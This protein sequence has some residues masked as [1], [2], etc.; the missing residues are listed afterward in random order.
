MTIQPL[1]RVMPFGTSLHFQPVNV[2]TARPEIAALIAESIAEWS[3]IE[4]GLGVILAVILETEAQTGLAMLATL[5]SSSAQMAV[6]EAAAN[7]KLT[8]ADQELFGALSVLIRAA[9]KDRHKLAHWCWM[10]CGELP[11]ALLMIEPGYQAQI[12]ANMLGYNDVFADVDRSRIYVL[13]KSDAAAIARD[14]KQVFEAVNRAMIVFCQQDRGKR[15]EARQKLLDGPRMAAALSQWR[16]RHPEPPK[17]Q[18]PRPSKVRTA[19]WSEAV[20]ARQRSQRGRR[21]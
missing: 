7:A 5:N 10:H 2:M 19:K 21:K 3:Q 12:F 6:V 15:A 13:G 9:A 11:D 14:I 17:P 8:K 1:S 18:P 4:C 16:S 20:R